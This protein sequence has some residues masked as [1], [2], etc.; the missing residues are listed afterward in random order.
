MGKKADEKKTKKVSAG[1]IIMK[2]VV[3]NYPAKLELDA[4]KEHLKKNNSKASL[5]LIKIWNRDTI[6]TLEYL[7]SKGRLK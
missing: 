2:L 4:I 5:N 3:D 7:S 6:S 1:S